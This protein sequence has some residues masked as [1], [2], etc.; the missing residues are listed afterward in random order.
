[1][2]LSFFFF[3]WTLGYSP[4]TAA[5]GAGGFSVQARTDAQGARGL[6]GQGR[7]AWDT[8]PPA[9]EPG[10]CL[11]SI[12]LNPVHRSLNSRHIRTWANEHMGLWP[13]G[14]MAI[15][16]HGHMGMTAYGNIVI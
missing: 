7:S 12:I 16:A 10:D 13:Y 14:T 5:Q 15:W 11:A 4:G 3:F 9:T 8:P 6:S 1:M 2:I